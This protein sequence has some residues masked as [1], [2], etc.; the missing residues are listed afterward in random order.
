MRVGIVEV[1]GAEEVNDVLEKEFEKEVTALE[2]KRQLVPTID[3]AALGA[4][5]LIEDAQCDAVV[6]GYAL[7]DGEKLSQAFQFTVLNAQYDLK[8]NIFRVIVPAD[9]DVGGYASAAAKEIIRYFYKPEEL[10]HERSAMHEPQK[11]S[12]FNPFAMFG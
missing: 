3:D 9:Q 4:R 7:E 8:R 10:Q 1:L 11:D 5:K 2:I 6:I 12:S